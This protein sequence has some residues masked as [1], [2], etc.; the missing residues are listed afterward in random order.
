[1]KRM[2]AL[3]YQAGLANVFELNA[4]TNAAEER[5]AKRLLQHAFQPCEWYAR[6][7]ME[8]GYA[9]RVYSCNRAGDITNALWT[10]GM[11]DCPFRFHANPPLIARERRRA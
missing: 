7:M 4:F 3:V 1:M 9:V 6:G 2:I 8:A 10:D 5:K 11:E